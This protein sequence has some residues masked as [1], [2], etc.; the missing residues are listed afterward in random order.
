MVTAIFVLAFVGCQQTN[1]GNF[2]FGTTTSGDE[3]GTSEPS[4]E[5]AVTGDYNSDC[6][7]IDGGSFTVGAPPELATQ[8]NKSRIPRGTIE[9]G[10]F[11][12]SDLPFPGR[13]QAWPTGGLNG[14]MAASLDTLFATTGRH[15][16]TASEY[17]VAVA[18]EFNNRW[19]DGATSWDAANCDPNQENPSPIGDF[20]DCTST[21]GIGGLLTFSFWAKNDSQFAQLLEGSQ[22]PGWANETYVV[23]GGTPTALDTYYGDDV[24]AVHGHGNDTNRY[25]DDNALLLVTDPGTTEEQEA[26]YTA[27]IEKLVSSG[28]D[29][30]SLVD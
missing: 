27:I 24:W 26:K 4:E 15:I 13:G 14:Q 30:S 10:D 29:W 19:P 3:S 22:N 20:E 11:C 8:D 25:S 16:A 28:G 17:L 2:R 12:I 23:V 1:V 7:H 21:Y 9:V 6:L 5:N 18:T